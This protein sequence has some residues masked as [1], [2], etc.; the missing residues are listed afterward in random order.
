MVAVKLVPLAQRREKID[1][2][3]TSPKQV[4]RVAIRIVAFTSALVCWA[5]QIANDT[6]SLNVT[7]DGSYQVAIPGKGPVLTA[8][9]GAQVDHQWLRSSDYPRHRTSESAFNDEVGSGREVTVTFSGLASQPDF[10]CM[11]PLY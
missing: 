1:V 9:V 5:E 10:V 2:P 3:T 7:A 11:L 6:L 8:R 4:V